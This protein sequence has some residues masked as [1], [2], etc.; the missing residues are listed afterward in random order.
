MLRGRLIDDASANYFVGQLTSATVYPSHTTSAST[1]LSNTKSSE[2]SASG[3]FSSSAR[4]NARYPV[5]YSDSF[6]PMSTFSAKVRNRLARYFHGG[7]PPRSAWP[8]RMRDPSTQ[9]YS[10]LAIMS[11]IAGMSLGVYW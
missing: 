11:A 3:S 5:W 7:M 10:P 8:P 4:E 2:F 6:A 1:W 9:A